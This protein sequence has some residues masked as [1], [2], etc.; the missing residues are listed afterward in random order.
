MNTEIKVN[1]GDR[2]YNISIGSG[3]RASIG[4]ICREAG[5]GEKAL[6]VTDSNV[7]PLYSEG[8]ADSLSGTGFDIR[9]KVLPAGEAT[10][11]GERLFELYD[12]AL[13]HAMDRRSC[14]IAL[15]GGVVGDI[16]GYLAA[17]Y[18]RGIPFVQIPTTLL[19][20]VDSSVGGKTGINLPRGKNLV[21]AFHQ[22]RAVVADIDVLA[23]L[24]KREWRAGLAEVIKYGIIADSK[25]FEYLEENVAAAA[26]GE[27]N[28]VIEIVG[29]S[30][31][32]KAEVVRRDEREG[33]LRAILN[34]G[35]TLGHAIENA[36]GYGHYLH[37]EA[38][39]IGM[40]YA[41]NLS[42]RIAGLPGAESRRIEHLLS[43]LGLPTT[44]PE[45][46]WETLAAAMKLDKKARGGVPL[47]VLTDMLG[48]AQPGY[49]CAETICREV[50]NE[51]C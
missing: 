17:S 25:F 19:A 41:A 34:F 11:C 35:H 21:G 49:E 36:A 23:T 31:E 45:L 13:D 10:K 14:V 48:E 40:A 18:L 9:T 3:P 8:V 29:K 2:S 7:G 33:G 44:A 28:T 16:A 4:R 12:A 30:C 15:G 42:V 37:G 39:A 32:I 38:V 6:L 27:P 43:V 5:L 26:S 47:F 20:M 51:R 22:P 24:P 1:L 50:W 46:K